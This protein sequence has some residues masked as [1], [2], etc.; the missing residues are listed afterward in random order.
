M[1][2]DR[3]IDYLRTR[4]QVERDPQLIARVMA[5][6]DEAPSARSP[7][8]RFL[9]AVAI[10]GVVG[11]VIAM[12]LI[13]GRNPSVG[14]N[15]TASADAVPTPATSAELRAA[16]ESG[17]EVLRESPGVEGTSSSSVL[18]ELGAATWFSWRPN[19]DQIV[20]SRTDRDVSETAWWL[21]P[22]VRATSSRGEHHADDL[23]AGG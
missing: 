9:P 6:I 16:V 3:V 19:G 15:P 4:A 14:P 21:D 5:A 23:R 20:I 1:S 10:A 13:F 12:V 8:A 2:D 17:L 22:G 7:F 18:G 11:I